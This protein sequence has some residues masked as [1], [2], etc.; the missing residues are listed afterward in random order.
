MSYALIH[1]QFKGGTGGAVRGHAR[2]RASQ[3]RHAPLARPTTPPGLPPTAGPSSP[4]TTRVGWEDFRDSILIPRMQQGIEGGF[5][6]PPE[7][8]GFEIATETSS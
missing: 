5:A 3:R 7:E 4:F 6:G 2:G 8:T 1:L